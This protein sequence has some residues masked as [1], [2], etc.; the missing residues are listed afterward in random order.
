MYT[1]PLHDAHTAAHAH[2][3]LFRKFSIPFYHESVLKEYMHVQQRV[4]LTDVCYLSRV[5]IEGS[6][7]EQYLNMLSTQDE[8]TLSQEMYHRSLLCNPGGG[9]VGDCIVTRDE[10]RFL[11]IVD[12]YDRET[13]LHWLTENKKHYKVTITDKTDSLAHVLIDGSDAEKALSLTLELDGD[14]IASSHYCRKSM[15]GVPVIIIGSTRT[16]EK[17]YELL[18]HKD[19]ALQVWKKFLQDAERTGIAPIGSC[20]REILRIERGLPTFGNEID[21][22]T[23][24][25]DVNLSEY[26]YL[27]KRKF[28]GKDALMLHTESEISKRLVCFTMNDRIIPRKGSEIIRDDMP[29][30]K[31]TSGGFSPTSQKAIGMG[32]VDQIESKPGNELFIRIHGKTHSAIIIKDLFKQND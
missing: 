10:E 28:I 14:S 27:R 5:L 23:L 26:V 8:A 1:S 22:T 17:G 20:A 2:L 12:S 13:V 18:M 6:D 21:E 4:G 30:G 7:A 24:P 19:I 11:L 25:F 31:V 3:R 29:V 15:F 16:G 32:F 9:I